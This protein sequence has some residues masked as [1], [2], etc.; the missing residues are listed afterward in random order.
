[1]SIKMPKIP[2]VV[3]VAT[4]SIVTMALDYLIQYFSSNGQGASFEYA[5]VISVIAFTLLKVIEVYKTN[6]PTP[7]DARFSIR[8]AN[9]SSKIRRILFG[10]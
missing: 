6:T 5:P 3:W 8:F 1:M 10:D 9:H 2:S 4:I 7:P